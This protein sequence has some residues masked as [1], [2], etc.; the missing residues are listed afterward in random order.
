MVNSRYGLFTPENYWLM[1]NYLRQQNNMSPY[2]GV[3]SQ[4]ANPYVAQ[5]TG[6]APLQTTPKALTVK[7]QIELVDKKTQEVYE[8]LNELNKQVDVNINGQ[9]V[10]VDQAAFNKETGYIAAD[11]KDDG[12]ISGWEMLKNLGK[13]V[14]NIFTNMWTDE[15]GEFSWTQLRNTA[16][17]VAIGAAACWFFPF[18]APILVGLGAVTGGI[19]LAKGAIN[20]Y[21]STTDEE[22]ERAWQDIGSGGLQTI[23]SVIGMKSLTKA[24]GLKWYEL[25][26]LI[27][28]G[29][30]QSSSAYRAQQFTKLKSMAENVVYEK[31]NYSWSAD[32]YE[33]AIAEMTKQASE[34]SGKTQSRWNLIKDAYQKI[35]DATDDA[36]YADATKKLNILQKSFEKQIANLEAQ[37]APADEI[38]AFKEILKYSRSKAP[39]N[40]YQV[41]NS[42]PNPFQNIIKNLDDEINTART[43]TVQDQNRITMLEETKNLYQRL[44]TAKTESEH[45]AVLDALKQLEQNTWDNVLNARRTASC[46]EDELQAL[47]NVYQRAQQSVKNAE[48]VI[49]ARSQMIAEAESI[50]NGNTKYASTSQQAEAQ[51]AVDYYK[52]L[53]VGGVTPEKGFGGWFR[54]YTTAQKDK[55]SSGWHW[56]KKWLKWGNKNIKGPEFMLYQSSQRIP[57]TLGISNQNLWAPY[58]ELIINSEREQL[59]KQYQDTIRELQNARMN[60]VCGRSAD[61]SKLA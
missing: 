15:K 13:G 46:T 40:A 54:R 34:T 55:M 33:S 48:S 27:K 2:A 16:A 24:N 36:S 57:E 39:M 9:A 12:K 56:V 45:K 6:Q 10:P 32:K 22:A 5:A 51:V 4:S 11:G 35:Y 18:A 31:M 19:Q 58:G 21:A 38:A 26:K 3:R 30:Q 25:D 41:V 37:N 1:Q 50:V 20:A 53:P 59:I 61:L 17:I 28:N 7:E 42:K 23:L 8:A 14:A 43:A 52:D 29:W 47:F 49:S 60:L 44:Y